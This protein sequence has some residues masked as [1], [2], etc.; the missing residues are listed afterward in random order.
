M[1]WAADNPLRRAAPLE[2]RIKPKGGYEGEQKVMEEAEASLARAEAFE[3][4]IFLRLGSLGSH[5]AE[6]GGSDVEG[7][8]RNSCAATAAPCCT[9][10]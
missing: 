10:D 1:A 6:N 2:M 4:A 8:Y 9:D 5:V 7:D 3:G